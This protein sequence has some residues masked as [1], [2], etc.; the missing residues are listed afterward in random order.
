MSGNRAEGIRGGPKQKHANEMI[1][2]GGEQKVKVREEER[3]TAIS[4]EAQGETYK[5]AQGSVTEAAAR[6]SVRCQFDQET[7]KIETEKKEKVK[8][9]FPTDVP[10]SFIGAKNL[11]QTA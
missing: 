2:P 8:T 9:V 1:S 7:S 4:M 10:L 3:E 11:S 5:G 6:R